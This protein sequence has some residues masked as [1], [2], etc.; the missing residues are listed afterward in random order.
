MMKRLLFIC[1]S[2]GLSVAVHAQQKVQVV[3]KTIRQDLKQVLD[4]GLVVTGRKAEVEIT[5][6]NKDYIQVELDLIAKH[7]KKKIAEEELAYIQYSIVKKG[8]H[9]ELKNRFFSTTNKIKVRSQLSVVYRI[10]LPTNQKVKISNDYGPLHLRN[11]YGELSI[12][13][14]FSEVFMERFFG[15][16]NAKLDYSEVDAKNLDGQLNFELTH[17][18]VLLNQFAGDVTF[19]NRLGD[20]ELYPSPMLQSLNVNSRSGKVELF[21]DAFDAFNYD[22]QVNSSYI[23]L[24]KAGSRM[25]KVDELTNEHSFKLSNGVSRANI[26]IMNLLNPV[27]ILVSN[28]D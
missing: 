12:D 13:A 15:T 27:R 22:V 7:P 19:N 24:P 8:Q 1:L 3:T 20:L 4:S 2:I 16:L 5:G 21:V 25:V 18:N 11:L 26:K 9:Y 28:E 23:S 14:K 17:T 10:F 6:W